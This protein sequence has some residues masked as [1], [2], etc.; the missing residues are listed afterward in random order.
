MNSA[1]SLGGDSIHAV[2]NDVYVNGGY[3]PQCVLKPIVN[4]ELNVHY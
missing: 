4:F 3:G 1:M 2:E